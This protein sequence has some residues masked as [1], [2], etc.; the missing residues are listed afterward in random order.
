MVFDERVRSDL[1]AFKERVVE[2]WG[3]IGAVLDALAARSKSERDG[4]PR[5][6]GFVTFDFGIDGVSIEIAKY[7]RCLESVLGG[8]S[9]PAD[10]HLIAGDFTEKADTVVDERWH[11]HDLPGANGWAKWKDGRLYSGMFL[12]DMP[13]GSAVA[14]EVA[15]GV[16]AD[17]LDLAERLVGVIL[18]ARLGLLVPVNVN[19]NPGNPATALA[20]V[21]ASEVCGL[22]VLNSCHD[23]YW[24]GGS[25]PGDGVTG[26][27][28]HFFRNY[29]N[30][31]FFDVLRRLFPWD[32]KAWLQVPINRL[33]TQRL[34]EEFGF[35][36]ERVARVGTAIEDGFFERVDLEGRR[37]LRSVMQRIL[38][39]GDEVLQTESLARF[40]GRSA[41]WLESQR[42]VFI[43]A[44]EG[45]PVDLSED[46][47]VF[48]QPTR[49]VDR[50]RIEK[51]CELLGALFEHEPFM[52]AWSERSRPRVILHITGPVPVEHL[53]TL[54]RVLL[55]FGS[56]LSGLS[57]DVRD[58]VF[59]AFSV[60]TEDHP[61]LADLGWSALEVA[62]L[63]RLG[64][65]VV[66]PSE[67]EGRGLPI[68]ES[69][70]V[71]VPIICSE[72]EPRNVFERVIGMQLPE[73]EQIAYTLFPE[74]EFSESCL[75][76]CTRL[77]FDDAFRAERVDVN[78]EV[79]RARYSMAALESRFCEL[80]E[81][82]FGEN[83]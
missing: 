36:D 17:A 75:T 37:H 30:R 8:D 78:R 5:S 45:A 11:R 4:W 15:R 57:E 59:L 54:Q 10:I 65:L 77:I 21:L 62:D 51:D 23:F 12:E 64:D 28:D 14:D 74:D 40:M 41:E 25:P 1:E 76:E 61:V 7:A 24:E 48:L 49:V 29:G 16:W 53:E 81:M 70:A 60:G 80:V 73:G 56:L 18:D 79:V 63:Y 52:S 42:P 46:A 66:F 9:G 82:I 31:A 69:S 32:G 39:G 44:V 33:Q 34:S 27:R 50:K 26:V 83:K 13:E 3:D 67:T 47:V 6:V 19:S 2:S 72:Y 68:V 43:G 20:V 71:G 22:P 55:A 58:R 38:A 35:S